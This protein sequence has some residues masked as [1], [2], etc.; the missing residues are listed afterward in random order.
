MRIATKIFQTWTY[1]GTKFLAFP[2][3]I[4]IMVID[5]FG[6]NYGAWQ[7]LSNFKKRQSKG[8]QLDLLRKAILTP[9]ILHPEDF[10]KISGY[11]GLFE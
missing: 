6:N 4:G 9:S 7:K 8:E 1:K 2:H 11:D 10:R 5:E 3:G